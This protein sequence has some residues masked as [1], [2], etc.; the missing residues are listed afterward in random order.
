MKLSILKTLRVLFT[1]ITS[2]S[3]LFFPLIYYAALIPSTA[4]LIKLI[5]TGTFPLC[6]STSAPLTPHSFILT[7]VHPLAR[8][9]SSF[10][11]CSSSSVVL[12]LFPFLSSSLCYNSEKAKLKKREKVWLKMKVFRSLILLGKSELH[13]LLFH[14][15]WFYLFKAT[16]YFLFYSENFLTGFLQPTLYFW[17]MFTFQKVQI[18]PKI[19]YI[20]LFFKYVTE[21]WQI[22]LL[23]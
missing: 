3:W 14:F 18:F 10:F 9:S 12:L 15:C 7:L 4:P 2:I 5:L 1:R 22:C 23:F 17:N 19:C 6:S 20:L 21:E 8:S 11:I 13:T 16:K